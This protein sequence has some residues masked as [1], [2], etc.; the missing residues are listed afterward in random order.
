[1][2]LTVLLKKLLIQKFLQYKLQTIRKTSKPT[3]R[4]KKWD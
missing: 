1:M 2:S 3:T 4:I